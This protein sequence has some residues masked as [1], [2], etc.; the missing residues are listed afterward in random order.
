MKR[1]L[2]LYNYCLE[3]TLTKLFVK[4]LSSF[5]YFPGH[6]YF[7]AMILALKELT[8]DWLDAKPPRAPSGLRIRHILY[9]A[10]AGRVIKSRGENKPQIN[11]QNQYKK[12]AKRLRAKTFAITISQKLEEQ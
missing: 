12:I 3:S 7:G 4:R 1:L 2:L 6:Q 9:I 10:I 5:V 11:L 8:D